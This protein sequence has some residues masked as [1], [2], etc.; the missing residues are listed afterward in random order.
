MGDGLGGLLGNGGGGVR[1]GGAEPDIGPM[2]HARQLAIVE[3]HVADAIDKGAVLR[4]GG[5]RGTLG[6]G[7]E[8]TVLDRCNH[9]MRV[10]TDETFG[11]VIPI[12]R[13]KDE[14]E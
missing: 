2:T 10:L 3:A 4:A 5:R 9:T 6:L 11:P 13:V 14:E 7:Y 1:T 12:V 8:P